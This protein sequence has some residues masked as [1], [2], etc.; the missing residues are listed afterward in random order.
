[1]RWRKSFRSVANTFNFCLTAT[2]NTQ[3]FHAAQAVEEIAA[4]AG[5]RLEVTPVGVGGAHPDQRHEKRDQRGGAEK[6]QRG[7]PVRG[8]NSTTTISSNTQAASAIW[9]R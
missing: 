8:K 4:E 5:Q 9:G 3:C 7:G 2:K 1:M 6:D